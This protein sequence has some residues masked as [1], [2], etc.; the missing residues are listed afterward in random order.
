MRLSICYFL[1]YNSKLIIKFRKS[2][3]TNCYK[4]LSLRTFTTDKLSAK[5]IS[6]LLHRL[7]FLAIV[8]FNTCYL[9]HW[10]IVKTK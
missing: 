10:T 8:D 9:N 7:Q 4:K 1:K 2:Y 3:I 6:V 5:N